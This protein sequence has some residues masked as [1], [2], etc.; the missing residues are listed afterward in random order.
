MEITHIQLVIKV[1]DGN[2]VREHVRTF[3]Y[4]VV[5]C[6]VGLD[7][8]RQDTRGLLEVVLDE[9]KRSYEVVLP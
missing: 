8:V 9:V 4:P 1:K 5:G 6:P 2:A 3:R 7:D